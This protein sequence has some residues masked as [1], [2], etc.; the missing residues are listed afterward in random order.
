MPLATSV[1]ALWANCMDDYTRGCTVDHVILFKF[2]AVI[3]VEYEQHELSFFAKG[4]NKIDPDDPS[5]L[6]PVGTLRSSSRLHRHGPYDLMF[7]KLTLIL[8]FVIAFSDSY[9]LF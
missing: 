7:I 6:Q 1:T 8:F 5:A 9:F 2:L 3:L 4:N